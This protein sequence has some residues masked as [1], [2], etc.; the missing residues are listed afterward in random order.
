MASASSQG[1]V[2]TT[3]ED[4]VKTVMDKDAPRKQQQQQQ[5]ADEQQQQQ[6]RREEQEQQQQQRAATAATGAA[7]SG[8]SGLVVRVLVVEDDTVNRTIVCSL[9]KGC[10]YDVV[11]AADG[12]EAIKL[13]SNEKA[14]SIYSLVLCD[15]MMPKVDGKG[16]LTFIRNTK[17]A[18]D[19]ASRRRTFPSRFIITILLFMGECGCP[20]GWLRI[21]TDRVRSCLDRALLPYVNTHILPRDRRLR[22]ARTSAGGY[23]ERA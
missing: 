21:V 8:A 19:R 12:R 18:A 14:G 7:A 17:G 13:L 16:V 15:I 1:D 11:A 22:R 2:K 5:E 20:N 23:D 4:G 3:K 9:L 10:G 6:Q